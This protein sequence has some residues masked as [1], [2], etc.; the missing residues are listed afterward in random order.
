[1]SDYSVS[2][3]VDTSPAEAARA[4]SDVQGWWTGKVAGS[5]AQP[6][7]EFTYEVEGVHRS[8]QRVVEAGDRRV[9]WKVIDSDLTFTSA[10]HEWTGTTL[11][12]E[13][14][15]H[16]RV[17]TI[18]FTHRGLV[19]A[20]ECYGDCSNAWGVLIT[21]NLRGWIETGKVQPSPW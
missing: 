2:I 14:R 18:V 11:D 15:S 17:T 3:T 13:I 5:S 12:F 19:P 16:G 4:I 9:V 1:M 7:D 8:S 20:F 21:K 10:K 6:G